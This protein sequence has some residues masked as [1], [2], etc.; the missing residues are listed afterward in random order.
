MLFWKRI[1]LDTNVK[2][3]R[4]ICPPCLTPSSESLIIYSISPNIKPQFLSVQCWSVRQHYEPLTMSFWNIKVHTLVLHSIMNLH[5]LAQSSSLAYRKM[6]NNITDLIEMGPFPWKCTNL[7]HIRK[8]NAVEGCPP[9]NF[10]TINH[11]WTCFSLS[12]TRCK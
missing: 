11:K 10:T 4:N 6:S 9:V 5:D 1:L 7:M 12:C 3:A 8:N 2:L